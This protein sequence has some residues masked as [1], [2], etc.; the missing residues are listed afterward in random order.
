MRAAV[1]AALYLHSLQDIKDK[2]ASIFIKITVASLFHYSALIVVP[3]YLVNN[4]LNTKQK[5]FYLF[6]P[7]IGIIISYF[8][9]INFYLHTSSYLVRFLLGSRIIKIRCLY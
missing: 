7:I 3:F 5:Y 8:D 2:T 1:A 9:I 4:T 6:L